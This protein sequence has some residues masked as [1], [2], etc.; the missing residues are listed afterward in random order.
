[1]QE[2]TVFVPERAEAISQWFAGDRDAA[3]IKQ[4]N[5]RC[6]WRTE[7]GEGIA[8]IK[9]FPPQMFRD[10]ARQEVEMLQALTEAGIGC[11]TV[12]AHGRDAEGTYVVTEE[13]AETEILRDVLARGDRTRRLLD[14]LGRFARS[15]HEIGFEH[16]DF[17]VGNI[18]VR[19]EEL[20]I[21]DVHRAKLGSPLNEDQRRRNIAF[22]LLSFIGFVSTADMLRFLRA[23]GI[24]SHEEI[25]EIRRRLRKRRHEH[26]TSRQRRCTKNSTG[27]EIQQGVYLRRGAD[28]EEVSAYAA[29]TDLEIVKASPKESLVKGDGRFVKRTTK[30][31][32]KRIWNNTHGLAVRGIDA[33]ALVACGANWVVGEWVDAPHLYTWILEHFGSMGRAERDAFLARFARTIRQMHLRGI[34]HRDLKAANVLVDGDRFVFTD[35]DRVDFRKDVSDRNR[36]FNLAQLN[37]SLIPPLTKTDR[38]RFLHYYF[39]WEKRAWDRRRTWIA[40]I[41]RISIERA[42]YWPPKGER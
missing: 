13:L 40:E 33:P 27:F 38:L 10:R 32:A 2:L 8:Y 12:L 30:S 24:T 5:A 25:R 21:I 42:H 7:M 26:F 36:I 39:A 18:L 14:A 28:L 34:I 1:M 6:V 15:L 23:C 31:R 41:M 35:L 22:L 37:A 29:R 17:H 16:L 11:P 3:I 9:R 20:F 4:N 19:D